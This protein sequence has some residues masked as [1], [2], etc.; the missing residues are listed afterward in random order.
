MIKKCVFVF[1]YS[2]PYNFQIL[3]NLEFSRPVFE[4]YTHIKFHENPSSVSRIVPCG[5]TVMTKPIVPFRS[6]AMAHNKHRFVDM[7]IRNAVHG[8]G[9]SLYSVLKLPSIYGEYHTA[10]YMLQYSVRDGCKPSDFCSHCNWSVGVGVHID[11]VRR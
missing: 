10:T 2:T 3:I 1:M 4:Q 8:N 9:Q 7:V 6:L 11:M 5:R